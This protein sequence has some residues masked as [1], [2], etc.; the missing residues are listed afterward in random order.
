MQ[1]GVVRLTEADGVRVDDHAAV[2]ALV[3]LVHVHNVHRQPALQRGDVYLSIFHPLVMTVERKFG[4]F[5]HLVRR[6]CVNADVRVGA[7][8][9]RLE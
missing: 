8:R 2:R 5:G 6:L 4:V 1:H 7:L 3:R 9:L